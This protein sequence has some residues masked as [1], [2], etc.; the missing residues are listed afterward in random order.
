MSA[1]STDIG[2]AAREHLRVSRQHEARS[3]LS[4]YRLGQS[5]YDEMMLGLGTGRQMMVRN[6]ADKAAIGAISLQ[7]GFSRTKAGTWFNLGDA[8]QH[9]PK[10]RIAYLAGEY[11]TNRMAKMVYAAQAAPEGVVIDPAKQPSAEEAEAAGTNSA[12][13]EAE[14][15]VPETD[16]ADADLDGESVTGEPAPA[17]EAVW[18][19]EDLALELGSRPT[20]D[21]VLQDQLAEAVISLD[22]EGAAR[23][24]EGFAEAWQNLTVTADSSGHMN[25]DACVPAEDGVFLSQRIAALI[26]ER[27]C[28]RDPRR[29]GQQR[30]MALAEITGV[31]GKTL[32]CRCGHG[33]CSKNPTPASIDLVGPNEPTHPTDPTSGHSAAD[34]I[35]DEA[36]HIADDPAPI[37]D[38]PTERTPAKT[39][40]AQPL[41]LR[42]PAWTLVLD[43]TGIEVP[44][45]RGY[46][47][48]DPGLATSLAEDSSLIT[49]PDN[50]HRRPSGLIV[51]GN[52]GCAPPVDPTGHGGHQHPPP[53][54]LT[55]APSA[56][57]REQ[58]VQR[59]RTCRYPFCSRPSHECELDHVVKFNHADRRAGGWTVDFNLAPLCTPDHHRK[60]LGM[61]LP[62]MHSDC[63]ITWRN[64]TAGEEIVTY[65]R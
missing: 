41:S 49:L 42:S 11:S 60:H 53:G 21:T 9:L 56:R 6:G 24:R 58:I 5:V 34:A 44:R 43:P 65:P 48:V 12:G 33:D 7:L 62:T 46:G 61:W 40:Q 38:V 20:T 2:D 63:T 59:D 51:V 50:A 55:H 13:D 31:P 30:V 10:F 52:R 19:F 39:S 64:P 23:A 32:T 15:D 27:V 54:A 37:D 29:I 28:R 1:P 22:P 45:L 57:L 36:A 26:A 4:A 18:D 25:V 35:V 16:T 8:L 14:A 3:L 47:A 17:P